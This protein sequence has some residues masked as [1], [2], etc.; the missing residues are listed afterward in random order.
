MPLFHA[1]A[2]AFRTCA[3]ICASA[4]MGSNTASTNAVRTATPHFITVS[5]VRS[6]ESP[7]SGHTLFS[8]R[9]FLRAVFF[10]T[11]FTTGTSRVPGHLPGGE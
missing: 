2:S 11:F 3:L 8:S 10:A 6:H 7:K 5:A 1:G 9:R 4:G